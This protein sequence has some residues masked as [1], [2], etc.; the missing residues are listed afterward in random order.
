M[1]GTRTSIG[2]WLNDFSGLLF[3]RRCAGC[4]HGLYRHEK[5]LCTACAADLPLARYHDDPFNRVEQLFLGKVQ[6]E[7]AS[8]FLLFNRA[9]VAQR[10]LHRLKYKMDLDIGIELGR[11]M[12][13]DLQGSERFKGLDLVIAVPLHAS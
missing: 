4:D 11:M 13:Q 9:G 2:E 10:M 6:F 7:A 5:I 12:A 3:P 1:N 8:S